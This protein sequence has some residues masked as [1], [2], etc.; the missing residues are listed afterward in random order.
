MTQIIRDL[1]TWRAFRDS[2][3]Q[4]LG[5]VPTMG[6]LHAGHA[7]LLQQSLQENAATVLSIFINPTQFNDPND[8]EKYPRTESADIEIAKQLG[9][10]AVFIPTVAMMY[11]DDYRYQ[12]QEN[13]DSL[14][15]EGAI[16]PGHFNGMLTVVLKLLQIVKATH[17]YF[18]EKDWQQ[19]Q[20]VKAMVEAFFIDTKI[21]A[22]PIIRNQDGLPLSSRNS[23][24][25]PEDLKTAAK[26]SQI[27]KQNISLEEIKQ[28][29]TAAGFEIDYV[30]KKWQR[31]VA[32]VKFKQVRLLDNVY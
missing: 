25:S 16:R 30:E 21:I 27:L 13:K 17:A 7:S 12:I 26:F 8:L 20:L 23:R 22:C 15:L 10:T 14:D 31:K 11:P 5:F 3:T 1:E 28:Q 24:L 19:L 6:N 2:M 18:G 29:L 32:A 9:V 4:P